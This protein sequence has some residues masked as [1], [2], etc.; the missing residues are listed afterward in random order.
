M[1]VL[2]RERYEALEVLSEGP[3]GRM[4]RA[5]DHQ[6]DREVAIKIRRADT[7]DARQAFLDRVG[8]LQA[9]RPHPGH[10]Q[11][12]EDFFVEDDYHVV[13]EWVPG[14]SLRDALEQRG[15]P[16]LP[17]R[18]ALDYLAEAADA[19]DHLHGTDPPTPHGDVRLENFILA[20]SGRVVLVGFGFPGSGAG[21]DPG[22]DLRALGAVARMLLT[23]TRGLDGPASWPGLGKAEA[24]VVEALIGRAISLDAASRLASAGELVR[25]LRSRLEGTLPAG[26]VTF[27]LTD[28]EGSTK[29]WEAHPE[30]MARAMRRHDEIMAG[31]LE[32]HG[33]FLPRDQGEGDS[34][35]AVFAQAGPAVACARDVQLALAAEPWPEEAP[36][37]VRMALN[38]GEAELRDRNYRGVAV[39]RTARLR[40]LAFGGQ[41]LVG[42][43]TASLTE[44]SLPP[45]TSLVDLGPRML[46]D[47]N[48]P[49][50]V[51]ELRVRPGGAP[52]EALDED[53]GS[54]LAWLE[55]AGRAQFVGRVEEL[56]SLEEARERA[57]G[58][59]RVMALVAGE[60]GIGKTALAAALA[61]RAHAAGGLVLYGRWEE[62][63]LAPF[64]AFREALG[65][66]A[67]ACPRS[68]LRADLREH[69]GE[70]SRLF[71]E[72]AERIGAVEE[73]LATSG[74][75][76]RFRLFEALDGWLQSM[77]SRSPV[78]LVLD[79]LHWADRASLLLLQHLMRALR[80]TSLLVVATYRDTDLAGS[81]LARALPGLTRD[82]D[83]FRLTMHGL[84]DED[85][86]E[87]VGLVTGWDLD[88][89][90]E[91]LARELRQETAGN[92][93]FLREM[94][95]HL[96]DVGVA[97]ELRVP[98]TLRDLVRW[99]VERLSPEC[100]DVLAVASVI[101]QDFDD[102]VLGPA[103]GAGEDRLVDLLE[104]AGRAGLV[105]EV[106]DEAGRWTFSHAVVRR[107]LLDGLSQT[108]RTRVHRRIAEALEARGGRL[109]TAAELAHH[110][111]ASAGTGVAEKA[112]RYSQLAGE[113]ARSEVAYESAV[114][115]YR[116]ALDV[117]DRFGPDDDTLRC[118]LLL[119]LG[120][121]HD[122]AG[123]LMARDER[124]TE[125][126]GVARALDRPDLF[127]GAALGYG[128]AW[129]PASLRPDP[130]AIALLE[131]ALERL[132]LEDGSLRAW[133]M[134]R[135]SHWLHY[136][137]PHETRR[138]LA[139][140]AEAM[141]RRVGDPR[142]L[143]TVLF[144]RCWAL[145]GPEDGEDEVAASAE[146]LRLADELDDPEVMMQ[147]IRIRLGAQFEL[148]D[149][150]D[151]RETSR[152]FAR[153]AAELRHPEY[154]RLAG[155]W[156]VTVATIEGRYG[157][158]ERV[159]GELHA[160]LQQIGHP[161]A[162]IQYIGQTLSWRWL[163]GRGPDFLPI[164]QAMSAQEPGTLTWRALTAW[165]YAE[166]EDW[167]R[168]RQVLDAVSPEV[169]AAMDHNFLWWGTIVPFTHAT[170]LIGDREW[171]EVLYEL[172]RPYARSNCTIGLSSFNG[173]VAHYL[174]VLANVLGRWDE[175]LAHLELALDRHVAMSAPAY[176][177]LTRQAMGDALVGRDEPGDRERA[178]EL[179]TAALRTAEDLGLGAIRARAR[180][181]R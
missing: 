11:V 106:P 140:E 142:T 121:A 132:G 31:A 59:H 47:L 71:P 16:G 110:F 141:A 68:I 109:T 179:H 111:V 82:T 122:L 37:A 161:Q 5:R 167:D 2:I 126:A 44:E 46:R 108:R 87:L 6:H 88:R 1:S 127:A 77:A 12:R 160:R 114:E 98:E 169:A 89:E 144:H 40:S 173:A 18:E 42:A 41:V 74:E 113:Q 23:G 86:R 58:G 60:P 4:V 84:G 15:D 29:L 56:A 30:A 146:V 57:A 120:A 8:V 78:L 168:T 36:L 93:F 34:I 81:E 147:G 165:A 175:A 80:P 7:P 119:A 83:C 164:W 163:Q 55:T 51:Y 14:R 176:V 35:L 94:L 128:G 105:A 62:E 130:R 123:E 64:Q 95:R 54:N 26:T 52:A 91:W 112:V 92:P 181:R 143:A 3:G 10:P 66:Y 17:H 67:R 76:E 65:E 138:A 171:A 149:W 148:G 157:D 177:A 97:G 79:D 50:H 156:D 104:E 154:L 131:E 13:M 151:A 72:V 24:M 102:G 116:R 28:V 166:A 101:G 107:S 85:V 153:V 19:L 139:D 27:L 152:V 25:R 69:G 145:D 49:E 134:G 45:G 155:A 100:G 53:D 170:A 63:A 33:G 159:A 136:Q 75:A 180:L 21:L 48:R 125:A 115:H 43:S 38:T 150:E 32:R 22:E 124:F 73:P 174:G 99:R 178:A 172:A 129:L 61:R 9:L 96:R 137:R 133:A 135:L 90:R 162:E 70:V 118:E 20:P 158:S 117:L 39:N 103:S